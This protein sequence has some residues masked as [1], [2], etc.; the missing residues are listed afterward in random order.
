VKQSVKYGSEYHWRLYQAS[1]NRVNIEIRKSK[2]RYY[3]Q[4]ISECNKNDPITT[5]K[6]I[7]SLTGR[8]SKTKH[9]NEI[10]IDVKIIRTMKIYRKLSMNSLSILGLN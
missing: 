9:I 6:L 8:A 7:N 4:K 10:E 1:R 5:W 3:C 2:S